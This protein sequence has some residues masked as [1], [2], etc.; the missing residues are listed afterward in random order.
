MRN[1]KGFTLTE[2]LAV[3]TI[4]GVLAAISAPVILWFNKPLQNASNQTAGIFKQARMRAIA[5]TSSLRITPDPQSPTTKFKVEASKTRG[6]AAKTEL[7][8][9]A[10]GDQRELKV[11]ST[12]GFFAGDKIKVGADTSNN[13]I[14]ATDS[15]TITLGEDLGTNQQIDTDVEVI[16]DWVNDG[17]F[18]VGDLILPTEIKMTSSLTN[19]K[20]CF[21]SRGIANLDN[22]SGVVNGNLTITLKNI[23]D[24]KKR[25]VKIFQGGKIDIGDPY[26]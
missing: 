10:E 3:V 2:S 16:N 7:T 9:L 11:V 13:N 4:F 25:D 23:K 1:S 8:E 26:D 18:F 15:S 12:Q 6:C 21:D 24:D 14:V 22:A 19:W 5:T 20:L 17:S